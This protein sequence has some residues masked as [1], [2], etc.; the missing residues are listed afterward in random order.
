MDK[1]LLLS[2]GR[3][4]YYGDAH[5]SAAWFGEAGYPIPF[6]VSTPDH[7]LDLACGDLPGRSASEAADAQ[8][9]LVARFRERTIGAWLCVCARAARLG[10]V[11]LIA[12][13]CCTLCR[14]VHVLL[15][16]A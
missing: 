12:C 15:V 2:E 1:L 11:A 5:A 13:V 8:Q 7:L 9:A 4:M 3:T 10:E 16:C 14:R 6:G